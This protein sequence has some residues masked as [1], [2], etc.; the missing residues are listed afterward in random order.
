MAAEWGLSFGGNSINSGITAPLPLQ[1][2][3]RLPL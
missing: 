2:S 1:S 3:H